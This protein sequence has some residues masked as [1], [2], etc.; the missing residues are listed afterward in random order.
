MITGDRD[1]HSRLEEKVKSLGL[2]EQI[3]F[4]GKISQDEKVPHYGLTDAHVMPSY[5]EG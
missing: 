3:I 2:S 4:T 1:D 5:R